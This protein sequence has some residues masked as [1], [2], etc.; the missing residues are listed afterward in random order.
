MY[1]EIE[2]GGKSGEIER[3]GS[4]APLFF[5]DSNKSVGMQNIKVLVKFW[6]NLCPLRNGR[7]EYI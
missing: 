5:V 7:G 1:G 2:S 3:W 4:L 6:T